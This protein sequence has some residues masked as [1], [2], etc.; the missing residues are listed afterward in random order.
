MKK[1][2]PTDTPSRRRGGK[3]VYGYKP[4]DTRGNLAAL[5]MVNDEDMLLIVGES[6]SI[7][8]NCNSIPVT[9]RASKGSALIKGN[10]L[11]SVSKI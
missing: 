7:C 5:A 8:I 6:T 9:T 1:L 2:L 10:S 3:G 4:D 11:V